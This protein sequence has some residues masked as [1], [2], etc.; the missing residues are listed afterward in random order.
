MERRIVTERLI[1]QPHCLDDLDECTSM[2]SD[3]AVLRMIRDH[4]FSRHETWLRI[5]RYAG[6]WAM[7]GYGYWTIRHRNDGRFYGELG[8]ALTLRDLPGEAAGLPEF[9]CTLSRRGWGRGIAQE[10]TAGVL[11]WMDHVARIEATSAI[12]D[13]RNRS[14]LA[15]ANAVGYSI[16]EEMDFEGNPF[17]VLTRT[18]SLSTLT[19]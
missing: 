7:L 2:W 14:A 3:P 16:V 8:F 9:G 5:L 18:S 12:T 4:P 19:S 10:A 17:A 1:L 11:E 6:H 13:L 15:L